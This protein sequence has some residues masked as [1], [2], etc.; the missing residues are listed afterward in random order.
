MRMWSFFCFFFLAVFPLWFSSSISF[1]LCGWLTPY[2]QRLCSG[3]R[4][5]LKFVS[6][7]LD[8][9]LIKRGSRELARSLQGER[10][11]GRRRKKLGILG[12]GNDL[13][14]SASSWEPDVLRRSQPSHFRHAN[15]HP[16]DAGIPCCNPPSS[17]SSKQLDS[18]R[19][20]E[21]RMHRFMG[22]LGCKRWE[23]C[24]WD[25]HFY[26]ATVVEL[27][28]KRRK[29]G[30]G[31]FSCMWWVIQTNSGQMTFPK[32][33]STLEPW[34]KIPTFQT[35]TSR[36]INNTNKLMVEPSLKSAFLLSDTRPPLLPF[37]GFCVRACIHTCVRV[38]FRV[39]FMSRFIVWSLLAVK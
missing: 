9:L 1:C 27:L 2:V 22:N 5:T 25:A 32:C 28:K 11:L 26:T 7:S 37:W 12:S 23:L 31:V 20:F 18:G 29:A 14:F 21:H 24:G 6:L 3:L 35:F 10:G 36:A 16:E 33:L 13:S 19:A 15:K 30:S 38:T 34:T 4:K 17:L 39:M 8:T